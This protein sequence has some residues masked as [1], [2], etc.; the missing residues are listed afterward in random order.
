MT[1][2]A[3]DGI[4][5]DDVSVNIGTMFEYACIYGYDPVCFWNMFIDSNIAKE[6]EK[7]NPKYLVG[8]SAIDLLN[9]VTK[10]DIEPKSFFKPSKYYWAGWVLT[11]YQNYKCSSFLKINEAISIDKVIDLYNTL[12]EADITKFYE[13][14]DEYIK[15]SQ[16]ATNLKLIRT[17][18]NLSQSQ[19]AKKTNVS[20]RNIQMYEQRK[21]DINKAQIDILLKLSKTLGC[22]IEDLLEL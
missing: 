18:A 9:L 15:N 4:Y 1:L 14:A 21:N 5:V 17:S 16:K 6:V 12:H 20:I 7:G 19:L 11:Q 13:I 8:F 22:N 2:R 10:Q 3:Y